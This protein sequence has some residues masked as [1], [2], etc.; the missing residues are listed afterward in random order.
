MVSIYIKNTTPVIIEAL[1]WNA[2]KVDARFL[3]FK[4]TA[5]VKTKKIKRE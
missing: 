4:Y 3:I 5:Q 1:R 2:A